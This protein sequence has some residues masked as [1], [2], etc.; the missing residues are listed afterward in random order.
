MNNHNAFFDGVKP[1]DIIATGRLD[2]L[3]DT[4]MHIDFLNK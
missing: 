3:N 1:V 4:F 2:D